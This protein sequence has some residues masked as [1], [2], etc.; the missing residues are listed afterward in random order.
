MYNMIMH[1]DN[2]RDVLVWANDQAERIIYM[3]QGNVSWRLVMFWGLTSSL[4][5]NNAEYIGKVPQFAVI[6]DHTECLTLSMQ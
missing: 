4:L 5:P 2:H 3:I 6:E 1:Q